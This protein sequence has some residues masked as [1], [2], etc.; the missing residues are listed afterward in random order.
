MAPADPD[1]PLRQ[2][3]VAHA[4]RLAQDYDDLVPLPRLRDGFESAGRRVSFGSLYRAST[5][6][7]R[8]WEP[9]R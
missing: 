9:R 8:N 6:T 4:R 2:A 7:A 5:V 1:L 3:A